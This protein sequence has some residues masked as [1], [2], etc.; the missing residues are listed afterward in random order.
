M[1]LQLKL[2]VLDIS[3]NFITDIENLAHL[4]VF[5][6]LWV[7]I[8]FSALNFLAQ[9]LTCTRPQASNNRIPTLLQLDTQ[10][11]HVST[12]ETIYLEGNP[13]QR[14]DMANYRRKVMLALPQVTQIDAT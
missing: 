10:L 2:R 11:R 3:N 8:I 4:P 6:A 14:E 1:I 5:E 13:C 9:P 12:L 7:R